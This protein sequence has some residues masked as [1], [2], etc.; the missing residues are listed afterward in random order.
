[1]KILAEDCIELTFVCLNAVEDHANQ[2][3]AYLMLGILIVEIMF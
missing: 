3:E 2:F 1:V